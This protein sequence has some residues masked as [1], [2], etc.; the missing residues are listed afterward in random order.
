MFDT[1]INGVLIFVII[2]FLI[3]LGLFIYLNLR[4]RQRYESK[5][6]KQHLDN[7]QTYTKQL[8]QNQLKL[9]KCKP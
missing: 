8:E 4:S 3:M 7:L 6:E 1:F 5:L 2:E 9:R